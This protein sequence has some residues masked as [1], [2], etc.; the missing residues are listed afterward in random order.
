[1]VPRLSVIPL[2]GAL[3]LHAPQRHGSGLHAVIRGDALDL[4]SSDLGNHN[5]VT[6]SVGWSLFAFWAFA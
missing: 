5:R 1:M 6:D 2:A 3:P 4:A